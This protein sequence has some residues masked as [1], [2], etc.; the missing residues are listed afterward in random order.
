MLVRGGVCAAVFAAAVFVWS[1]VEASARDY[2]N[3]SGQYEP[4]TIIVVNDDRY[5]YYVLENNRAIRYQIAGAI[6]FVVQLKQFADGSRK[7]AEIAE[8][9]G[10]DPITN[11]IEVNPV[12]ETHFNA[13]RPED[14]T[15][16]TFSGRTPE[17]IGEIV[18]AGFDAGLLL[19][20]ARAAADPA[21][22]GDTTETS[23][24]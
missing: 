11:R 20:R 22:A 18:Q 17:A 4:G 2:V 21:E 5:L 1:S 9:G 14:G 3:F 6:D 13:N 8:I 23:E 19:R 12:F 7:I 10:I 15:D 16:F 24:A